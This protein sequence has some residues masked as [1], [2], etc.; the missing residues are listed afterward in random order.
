MRRMSGT[1]SLFISGETPTWHQ[2]VGGLVILDVA[3][4]PGFGFDAVVRTVSDRLALIPK[5]TWKLKPVPLG[6]DRAVWVDDAEFDIRRHVHHIAVRA[7]GGPR[8]TAAA[9]APILSRQ[10]DRRYP[11]WEF[12]YVDGI[13]N[14]RV[15]V[16]MKFHHCMLDGGAGSVL[17]TLLLDT[18][19][20][21]KPRETPPLP[22]AEPEPSDLRLLAEGLVPAVTAPLR[23]AKYAVRSVRRGV[24]LARHVAAGHAMPDIGAMLRAPKTSFNAAIGP[25]RSMAFKS[26]SFADVKALRSHFDVRVNDVALA[27]CSG[28]LRTYLQDRGELPDRSLTAGIPVSIRAEGDTSLD[29]QLSYLV[30]PIATDIADPEARLRAIVR[31]TAAAKEVHKVMRANPVGSI[32]DTAPPFVLGTLLRLAYEAHVLSYVPGMMN[33]IVSNV[34]GP[35]MTLYMSGARLT[36]IF[37]ASVLLDQM[38]LN[39]TLFTFGGR[40]DFGVHVDP[41]LVEDPWVIANAIHDALAELMAAAG[42]GPPTPVEDAF[43]IASDVDLGDELRASTPAEVASQLPR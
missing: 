22:P 41:D 35:P 29:N 4:V 40:V 24:E 8:E 11:L 39:I 9:V 3:G 19:P 25:M 37:S 38:G 36:G 28:A 17:A 21:P 20:S 14:G 2:H 15:A 1:D 27:L 43:G 18:E 30:V 42:L 5:L 10:L 32:G 7:P 16:V 26:V 6:L 13:V 23:T 12:W 33:T 34:P 31:H